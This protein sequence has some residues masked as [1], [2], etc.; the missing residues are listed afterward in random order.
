MARLCR[1]L[2]VAIL[3]LPTIQ[4]S[5]TAISYGYIATFAASP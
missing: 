1:A 4:G 3:T 2:D 5:L